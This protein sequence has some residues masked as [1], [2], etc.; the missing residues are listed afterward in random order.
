MLLVR[1]NKRRAGTGSAKP[2]AKLEVVDIE[3]L[4]DRTVDCVP[5][6]GW[7]AVQICLEPIRTRVQVR[8]DPCK[9]R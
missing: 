6:I 5:V 2:A 3:I 1:V 8:V 4:K 7:K 9:G